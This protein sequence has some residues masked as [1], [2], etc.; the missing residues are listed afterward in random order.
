MNKKIFFIAFVLF[1]NL[2]NVQAQKEVL[3][4]EK[5]F[6]LGQLSD[7]QLSPDN[8]QL[9]YGIR[10]T[11]LQANKGSTD[12][13]LYNLITNKETKITNTPQ[14]ESHARWLPDGTKIAFLFPDANGANQIWLMNPDGSGRSQ[15]SN[16]A[17]GLDGFGF[18][19]DGKQLFYIK[20][21]K[22]GLTLRDKYPD[23]PKA[24]GE[25]YTGLM[26]RHWNQWHDGTF[27]HVFIQAYADGKLTGS[28]IDVLQDEPYDAP[29]KPFGS[30]EQIAFSADSK[31]LV[32]TCK[33]MKPTASAT[34][35]NSD[36]YAYNLDTRKTTNLT[37]SYGGYDMEPS[38]SPDGKMMAFLSMERDGY[39]ADKNRIFIRNLV[40]GKDEDILLNHDI[41]ASNLVWA[42]DSKSIFFEVPTLGTVQIFQWVF[43]AD[44]K[45]ASLKQITKGWHNYTALLVG[46]NK[47]QGAFLIGTRTSMQHPNELYF[48][49]LTK[50]TEQKLSTHNDAK[51]A[52]INFGKVEQIQIKAK[53]SADIY[54]WVIYPPNFD[55]KKK[56]PALLYC[57][58]GPQSMV[59]QSFSLRW[60]FQQMAAQGY[61]I[62]APNRRGLPG[63][64]QKWNEQISGDWGG[65]AMLDLLA[66]TDSALKH[67]NVDAKRLGAV[68]ASF[69]GYSV[70]WLAG[71]HQNRFK[72]F[73]A[74]CGVFNLESMYGSTEEV[75]FTDFEMRGAYWE[76]PRDYK[77]FSPHNFVQ[78]WNTP[79]LVI[80]NEKDF[81]VPLSEGLQAFTAA[82]KQKVQSEFLYFPDEGHWVV[83]PQNSILWNRVFFD[84]LKR[85]L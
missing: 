18:A 34:S 27:N 64:G 65:K 30:S 50:P 57:Q 40:S 20:T 11:D 82:Q 62:F 78:E 63:F 52:K 70:Y 2:G 67:P 26:Y 56:Y 79:L 69:G 61:I 55:S 38:F 72:A 59:G 22:V 44:K 16:V 60:N 77:R 29:L 45:P 48:I 37:P 73:I 28:P 83:K 43:A 46:Q 3:S 39:E 5:L 6:E 85:N 74:H 24:T 81:R 31:T 58:G 51:L 41:T 12:L 25:L 1:V 4:A 35:T 36:L 33:K 75:F 13:Y 76:N 42:K 15:L 66:V 23:L 54:T 19:P 9:V 68:G 84:F 49:G 32:Y 17:D 8:T 14:S 47:Q 53:D 80:H 10:Y 7:P 21:V 71:H